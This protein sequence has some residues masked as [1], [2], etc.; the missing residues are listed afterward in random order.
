MDSP[1]RSHIPM[2]SKQDKMKKYPG[3]AVMAIGLVVAGFNN[4]L[5]AQKFAN[6]VIQKKRQQDESGGVSGLSGLDEPLT[7]PSERDA[8]NANRQRVIQTIV[9]ELAALIPGGVDAGTDQ[10]KGLLE[11]ANRFVERD[12]KGLEEALDKLEQIEPALPPRGL[13]MAGIHFVL[14][15]GQV[16][17][18]LLEQAAVKHPD[19]PAISLAFARLA[20]AQ[21]RLTDALA[22]AEKGV[23]QLESAADTLNETQRRHYQLQLLDVRSLV[24]MRQGRYDDALQRVQ[25][26]ETLKADDPKMLIKRA[27]IEF[28]RGNIETSQEYIAKF[29]SVT[30]NSLPSE[31]ILARWYRA[32]GDLDGLATW[33]QK[34]A[35][36]YP[37]NDTVQ[38]EYANWALGNEDFT[39]ASK[40][41]QDVE[42]RSG[43]SPTTQLMKGRIAFAQGA[44]G[45]AE[46]IFDELNQQQ[47]NSFDIANMLGLSLAES[48]D[49]EKQTRAIQIAQRNLQSLPNSQVAQAALG[50]ALLKKGDLQNA[51]AIF[52]RVARM[53]QLAPEIAY[54]MASL[55]EQ[56]GK[57]AQAKIV[58]E[59]ALEQQGLFLYRKPA[60]ELK[61]RLEG[62]TDLPEPNKVPRP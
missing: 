23:R 5:A 13:L 37:D 17:Q 60:E 51:R 18:Q 12:G 9:E 22:L 38:L 43:E 53:P 7:R 27:E 21:N 28:H 31:L 62:T 4:P 56:E 46:T 44:Y 50:W 14:N 58:L 54:F 26:W 49:P 32:K 20:I 39:R 47:P 11:I 45:L 57:T 36:Q 35:N 34:A 10:A 2:P 6:D 40:A 61:V 8:A 16:G 48:A 30:P 1:I 29:R 3:V 59:P 55:L 19:H 42:A 33:I 25:Q 52:T 41:I 15:N 24:A